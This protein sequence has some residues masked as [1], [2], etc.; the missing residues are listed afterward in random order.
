MSDITVKP[1]D[2]HFSR[3][4]FELTNEQAAQ[5][6]DNLRRCSNA[7]FG[8]AD[9]PNNSGTRVGRKHILLTAVS[10]DRCSHENYF[11]SRLE[12]GELEGVS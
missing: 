7:L 5:L 4:S 1:I 6:L 3:V 2:S 8:V 9:N 12:D 10:K 11:K